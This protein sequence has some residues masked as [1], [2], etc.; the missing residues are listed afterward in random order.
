MTRKLLLFQKIIKSL[1]INLISIY[2]YSQEENSEAAQFFLL[3][4]CNKSA[5]VIFLIL[6]IFLR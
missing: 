2:I 1:K 4:T 3:L 6:R 5:I